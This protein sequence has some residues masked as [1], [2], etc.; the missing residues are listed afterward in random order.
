MAVWT[1]YPDGFILP[2]LSGR[3]VSPGI[4]AVCP[5]KVSGWNVSPRI[6]KIFPDGHF[7]LTDKFTVFY[8]YSRRFGAS[9]HIFLKKL[10]DEVPISEARCP[11]ASHGAR[12]RQKGGHR[13]QVIWVL[14]E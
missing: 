4:R 10:T 7:M 9:V 3:N 13:F 14:I 5:Y 8:L 12:N 1:G 11:F 6:L 2:G